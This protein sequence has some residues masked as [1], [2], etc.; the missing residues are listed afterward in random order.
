MSLEENYY[1]VN[2]TLGV[3]YVVDTLNIKDIKDEYIEQYL[4]PALFSQIMVCSQIK[5]KRII[6]DK[7]QLLC[8]DIDALIFNLGIDLRPILI[9]TFSKKD[10][11]LKL[12]INREGKVA[13]ELDVHIRSIFNNNFIDIKNA[14]EKIYDVVYGLDEECQWINRLTDKIMPKGCYAEITDI[15]DVEPFEEV[16]E[17]LLDDELDDSLIYY[18]QMLTI[19]EHTYDD[20]GSLFYNGTAPFNGGTPYEAFHSD[21]LSKLNI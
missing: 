4:E 3:A 7:L 15:L 19:I 8:D 1:D 2:I 6:N 13:I 14:R 21:C 20:I 10:D 17:Q 12:W 18:Y 16:A 5:A 9:S 11:K